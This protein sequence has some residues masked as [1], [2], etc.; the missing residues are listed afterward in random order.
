[1]IGLSVR[2]PGR[3]GLHLNQ[4]VALHESVERLTSVQQ[5]PDGKHP[6]GVV[7]AEHSLGGA[8]GD[9]PRSPETSH[10]SIRRSPWAWNREAKC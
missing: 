6:A 8:R 2:H 4:G 1:M 7:V 9:E 5:R 3:A 10:A